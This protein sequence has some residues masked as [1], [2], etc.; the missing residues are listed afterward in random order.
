M[1]LFQICTEKYR[2]MRNRGVKEVA[3]A[4]VVVVVG[5]C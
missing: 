3:A 5:E 4:V 2:V 1:I